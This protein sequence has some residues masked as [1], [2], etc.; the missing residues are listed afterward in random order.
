LRSIRN[1]TLFFSER[2]T[3]FY[4]SQTAYD[5]N[6]TSASSSNSDSDSDYDESME[7]I[8]EE[9]TRKEVAIKAT[10]NNVEDI[11]IFDDDFFSD[12]ILVQA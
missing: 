8:H 11:K 1:K 4:P 10:V 6:E 7:Q 2:N 5:W 12:G 9:L 3:F